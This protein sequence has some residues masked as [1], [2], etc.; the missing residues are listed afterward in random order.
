MAR[1]KRTKQDFWRRL[2]VNIETYTELKNELDTDIKEAFYRLGQEVVKAK[3][4]EEY[5]LLP[6]RLD[7]LAVFL[8]PFVEVPKSQ[9]VVK[10]DIKKDNK[11]SINGPVSQNEG[12][13]KDACDIH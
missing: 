9:K 2:K 6:S 10:K 13:Q 3:K 7:E 5:L 11:V 12:P 1:K 4:A 8:A